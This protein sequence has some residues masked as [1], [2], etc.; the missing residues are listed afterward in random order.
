MVPLTALTHWKSFL[1][2]RKSAWGATADSAQIPKTTVHASGSMQSS[3]VSRLEESLKSGASAVRSI[4]G[5][6]SRLLVFLSLLGPGII[7]TAAGNDAGGIL[8]YIQAGAE[9]KFSFLWAIVLV[10][11]AYYVVQEMAARMGAVT[12]KG[13]ADLIRENFGVKVTAFAM[14]V[15]LIANLATTVTEF[16]GVSAACRVF[17]ISDPL[18]RYVVM[19]VTM[20]ALFFLIAG[21]SYARVERVFLLMSALL[22]AYV[23]AAFKLHPNWFVVARSIVHPNIIGE[24]KLSGASYITMLIALI[25]TTIAPYQQFYLQSAIRDKGIS[26]KSYATTRFDVLLGCISSNLISIFIVV[27]CAVTLYTAGRHGISNVEEAS[28]VLNPLVGSFIARVLFGIGLL[29]ASILAAVIVPLTTAYAVTESLGWETG[30]GRHVRESPIF[31]GTYA[32]MVGFGGI[33]LMIPHWNLIG[34]I[35]QAQVLNG[36]LLPVELFLMILL[37]SKH[38]LMGKYRNSNLFNI[39]AWSTISIVVVVALADVILTLT[40]GL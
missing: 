11:P 21:N 5:R 16:A 37:C 23:V 25:G 33:L 30:V 28:H 3:P 12:G 17:G 27:A 20:V 4:R 10:T 29:G 9:F 19:P 38:W 24:I 18:V 14:S 22:L 7:A 31:Y 6:R 8:T 39:V 26:M 15:Q 40:G 36:V 34:L 1:V 13:L 2:R 32:A 35:I